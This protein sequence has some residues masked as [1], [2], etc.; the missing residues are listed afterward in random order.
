MD[1]YNWTPNIENGLYKYQ[2]DSINE[3]HYIGLSDDSVKT[4]I[5]DHAKDPRFNRYL[6]DSIYVMPLIN[7]AETCGIEKILIDQYKPI[8]NIRDK[9]PSKLKIIVSGVEWYPY[10]EYLKYLNTIRCL[11]TDIF[12]CNSREQLKI[13]ID[14]ITMFQNVLYSLLDEID[15]GININND[16]SVIV[17]CNKINGINDIKMLQC[18]F[19]KEHLFD[20]N[21]KVS[22]THN[23]ILIT[24]FNVINKG[25]VNNAIKKYYNMRKIIIDNN[26]KLFTTP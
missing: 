21:V 6:S 19:E 7:K 26:K 25:R 22:S 15:Y 9:Y 14:Y 1:F 8:L 23:G 17:V 4:R 10:D 18:L 16:G 12:S 20:K 24:G 3:I 13:I 5:D 11:D 2:N